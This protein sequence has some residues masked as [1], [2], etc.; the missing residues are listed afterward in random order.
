MVG[1]NRSV[2]T[3][4]RVEIFVDFIMPTLI[5]DEARDFG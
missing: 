2:K 1:I 5:L 4:E 3:L